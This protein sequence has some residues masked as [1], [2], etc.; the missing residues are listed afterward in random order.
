M[1]SLTPSRS[2][3][4]SESG[5]SFSDCGDSDTSGSIVWNGRDLDL[6]LT[7]PG[8]YSPLSKMQLY[9]VTSAPTTVTSSPTSSAVSSGSTTRPQIIR[10]KVV[11]GND[12]WAWHRK[13]ITSLY[14]SKR[15]KDVI[16]IMER[17]HNFVATQRMYKARFKQWGLQKNVTAEKVRMLLEKL[18]QLKKHIQPAQQ[19]GGQSGSPCKTIKIDVDGDDVKEV[20]RYI[21]RNPVGIHSLRED[22][23]SPLDIIKAL[24]VDTKGRSGRPEVSISLAKLGRQQS[25]SQPQ[26]Q[27]HLL[28]T[29]LPSEQMMT[30]M[31]DT[32][33][34]EGLPNAT[35]RHLQT[36]VHADFNGP[37][38]YICSPLPDSQT[39]SYLWQ[40]PDHNHSPLDASFPP[41]IH[42]MF[43]VD[44]MT[45]DFVLKFRVAHVLL[46]DGLTTQALEMVNI[47]LNLLTVRLQQT[48]GMASRETRMVLLFVLT[49]AL[50]MAIGFDHMEV[51]HTFFQH[52]NL[53]FAG[54]QRRIAELARRLPHVE[55]TQQVAMLKTARQMMWRAVQKTPGRDDPGYELYAK[56]VE[57]ANGPCS[58]GQKLQRLQALSVEPAMAE[59][60]LRSV[61]LDARI[62]LAVADA[63]WAAQQQ[64]LWSANSVWTYSRENKVTIFLRYSSD[65]L[66]A[67][68][69]AGDWAWAEWWATEAACMAAISLGDDHELTHKFSGDAE[70]IIKAHV[71]SQAQGE[72]AE[73][74]AAPAL[75]TLD[76]I[77]PHH[78]KQEM[79]GDDSETSSSGWEQPQGQFQDTILPGSSFWHGAGG[80]MDA[81][82]G[83][84]GD[85][86]F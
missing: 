33:G 74:M 50:E 59:F 34:A 55:R 12:D 48:Q 1:R 22:P 36:G 58:P 85:D 26:P 77:L 41:S 45:L 15:L 25:Q 42:D 7:S 8:P 64:G 5:S 32:M 67:F 79:T 70:S 82:A 10:G 81:G 52:L 9:S 83:L 68:T 60:P 14:L 84:F 24:T 35:T 49:A 86:S 27:F 2:D 57:I 75:D 6:P 28:S 30:W 61:W 66:D 72:E 19:Q 62:A 17:E 69:A 78:L 11:A 37:Y 43:S 51:L 54:Q 38:P 18:E 39:P 71:L 47:C 21:K 63:P 44:E 46:D 29:P 13:R 56:T 4:S 76:M 20:Q 40:S 16:A 53:L 3:S 23:N 80:A 31:P 73:M 65:K